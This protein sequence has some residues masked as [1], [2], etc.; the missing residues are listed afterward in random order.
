[1]VCDRRQDESNSVDLDEF[2]GLYVYIKRDLP[3]ELEARA[4]KQSSRSLFGTLFGTAKR[5]ESTI[6]DGLGAVAAASA[7]ALFSAPESD[8]DDDENRERGPL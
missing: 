4:K 5:R 1:M 3:A 2:L 6:M 8:D 7:D